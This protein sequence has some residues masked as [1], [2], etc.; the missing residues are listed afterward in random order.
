MKQ[1]S[2]KLRIAIAQHNYE[3]GALARNFARIEESVARAREAGADL[4]VFSACAMTGYLPMDLLL[5]PEFMAAQ[6]AFVERVA[7][8]SDD[9]LGI[10]V[11]FVDETDVDGRKVLQNSVALCHDSKV[12]ATRAKEHLCHGG[13]LDE[14]RYFQPGAPPA[15]LEFKG[16]RLGVHVWADAHASIHETHTLQALVDAGAQMIIAL[17][18]SAFCVGKPALRSDLLGRLAR[19]H[20]RALVWVN[21]VGAQD[22]LIYDGNS[23]VVDPRGEVALQLAEFSPD[24][25]IA[26]VE[27]CDEAAPAHAPSAPQAS[28]PPLELLIREQAQARK[29]IVLGLRD[30]AQKSGFRGAI[31]GLSGGIDSA[32]CAALAAEALGPQNV[33]AVAMPTRFTRE[34]SNEDARVLA[35]KLGIEFRK[36]PVDATF[37]AFLRQLAPVFGERPADVTEENLQARVRGVTLM[38]LSNKF[39]RIVLV[40]GNKSEI[41]MGYTTLY[42]DM[43]GAISPLGDCFKTQVYAMARGINADAGREIIPKRTIERAPSAELRPDQDDQDS[44]PPYEVLD[45]V[46]AAFI[47][48]GLSAQQIAARGFDAHLVRDILTRLFRAEFKR[49]Q[50]APILQISP[51]AFGPG[52]RFP[53]AARISHLF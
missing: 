17:A 6:R 39:G 44:L 41:A 50:G 48:E 2:K 15:P 37:E 13:A 9:A 30:Y 40:P 20:R 27:I 11:G 34:I 31:L 21:Q 19:Q 24:F 16:V 33:L 1:V 14:T 52:R 10:L 46:L 26:Q 53:L 35:E 38:A 25:A 47:H 29:A 3:M 45:A 12:V 4:V 42:G 51:S 8:L 23:R 28:I 5:R 18:A 7:A 22:E 36:I 49:R 32:L 43:V